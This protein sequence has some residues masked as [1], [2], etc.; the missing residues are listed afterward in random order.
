M[1]C[2]S[3]ASNSSNRRRYRSFTNAAGGSCTNFCINICTTVFRTNVDQCIT[4]CVA[5]GGAAGTPVCFSDL[6]FF[7]EDD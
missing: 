4:D 6:G 5:C 2:G 7:G 1:S 3:N